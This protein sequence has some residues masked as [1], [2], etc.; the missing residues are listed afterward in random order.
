MVPMSSCGL[1]MTWTPTTSPTRP[2]AAAPAS[3]AALTAATSPTTNA[4]TRPLPIFCQPTNVTLA[5]LSIAS[6]ASMSETRPL[7]SIMP[8]ASIPFAMMCV[9][10]KK[11]VVVSRLLE[12]LQPRCVRQIHRVALVRVDVDLQLARGGEP[13]EEVL[14]H[15]RAGATHPQ[16]QP[17]AVL[18]AVILGVARPHV[19]VAF[20]ADHA[21]LHL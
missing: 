20:V 11:S 12:Q 6:L 17:A 2:A 15:R 18:D 4:V 14:Q 19:D 21:A 16:V 3:T 5:A 1:G 10:R 7:V 13:H 8:S 9:P